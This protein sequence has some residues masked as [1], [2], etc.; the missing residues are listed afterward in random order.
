MRGR[1]VSHL[2]TVLQTDFIPLDLDVLVRRTVV[3]AEPGLEITDAWLIGYTNLSPGLSRVPEVPVTDFLIDQH[4]DF[5][6]VWEQMPND[7]AMSNDET[8]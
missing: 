1:R 2:L 8:E 3:D 4:N 5:L 6:A 7:G